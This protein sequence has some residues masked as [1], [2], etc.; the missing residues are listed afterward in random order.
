MISEDSKQRIKVCGIFLLQIYKITT[1]TMLSLFIPQSCGDKMCSLKENYD[2][3]EIYHKTL[4]YWNALSMFLFIICYGIEL[5]R[6]EWC[7]KFLDIDNNFPDNSLKHIIVQEKELDTHMDKLNKYYY[8]TLFVTSFIYFVNICMTLQMIN[9][10]Y[11]SSSTISCFMSF[12]L[13]VLMKLYNS[14][15][16][17]YQSVKND[18]MMSAYMCEFVSFNVLDEDYV[19]EKY[20]GKKNNRLEDITDIEISDED[21]FHDVNDKNV[22]NQEE[23]IPIIDIKEGNKKE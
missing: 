23:I 8:N 3:S 6:E 17:A 14:W 11:H 5:R 21:N 10:N 20:Q 18:K 7:V 22:V 9:N 1:G 4:F 12:T 13:L 15:T 19:Q 2:N 16:V